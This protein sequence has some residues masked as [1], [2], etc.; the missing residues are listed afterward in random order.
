MT[1][2]TRPHTTRYQGHDI[3]HATK[4]GEWFQVTVER[5]VHYFV[6]LRSA[7]DYLDKLFNE[8]WRKKK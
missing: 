6:D 4:P 5:V 2:T 8:R 1:T 3:I 7:M